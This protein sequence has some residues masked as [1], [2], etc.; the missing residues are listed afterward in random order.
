[1]KD[2][3]VFFAFRDRA[4]YL[5]RLSFG[6]RL[7]TC[8][9]ATRPSSLDELRRRVDAIDDRLHDLIMERAEV[10]EEIAGTK[11]RDGIAAVRPGR[12]ALILRR[13]VARHRGRFPRAVLVRLWRELLSGAIGMQG[14]FAVAVCMPRS[15]PD[16]WDLARDHYGSHTPMMAFHSASEVLRAMSEGRAAVGVLPMPAEG[17]STPWWPLLM[18]SGAAVPQVS[19]RLPFAGSGNARNDGGEAV[20]IGHGELDPTGADRSFIALEIAGELSRARLIGA[21]ADAGLVVTLFAAHE[22]HGSSVLHLVEIDDLVPP[23]DPRLAKALQP[24]GDRV[25]RVAHLGGYARPLA[26]AALEGRDR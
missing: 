1:V 5:Y 24:L 25:A 21:L 10:I 15:T 7:K 2:V 23:G 4:N 17:E 8:A 18:A 11:K 12:E 3:N 9:M 6:L 16:Y 20:V 22:P 14:N 26:P 19:A 13:L